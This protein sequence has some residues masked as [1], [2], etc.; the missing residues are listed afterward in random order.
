MNALY[1]KIIQ[2][3]T[4][5]SKQLFHNK[6]Q[7]KSLGILPF[8]APFP[9]FFIVIPFPVGVCLPSQKAF[10]IFLRQRKH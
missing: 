5:A 9:G 3:M 8:K 2:S 1:T 6:C 4:H 7:G 10:Y